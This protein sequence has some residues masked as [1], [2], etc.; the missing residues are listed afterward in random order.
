VVEI[1]S[2]TLQVS[3]NLAQ[4]DTQ[5][6][7]VQVVP[8]VIPVDI[9]VNVGSNS[10]LVIF[11]GRGLPAGTTC[12]VQII[13]GGVVIMQNEE[14]LR[15]AKQ[16]SAFRGLAPETTYGA[17]AVCVG[18]GQAT[19]VS[20]TT[21]P[22]E[23]STAVTVPFV[24]KPPSLLSGV[25]QV[26]FDWG[27]DFPGQGG[28]VITIPCASGCTVEPSMTADIYL[29]RYRWKDVGGNVLATSNTREVIV[30]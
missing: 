1:C 26:T 17:T 11:G 3:D 18:A 15:F 5:A 4:T 27:I 21:L 24:L 20:F 19:P 14:V 30:P 23:A 29:Y 6:L 10:A 25:T 7:T 12:T 13:D 9:S 28:N 16:R 22:L 2:F 8:L